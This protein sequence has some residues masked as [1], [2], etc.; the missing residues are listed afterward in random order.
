MPRQDV[1]VDDRP[2]S[3]G[4]T[5]ATDSLPAA[6]HGERTAGLPAELHLRLDQLVGWDFKQLA[7]VA[8]FQAQLLEG[9][10]RSFSRGLA[11]HHADA[12]AAL[13]GR[14]VEE[15][16][17][18]RHGAEARGFGS[19]AALAED[20]DVVRIAA[21]CADVAMH[22]LEAVADV[23]HALVA[24]GGILL[25]TQIAQEKKAHQ[26]QAMI[27]GDDHHIPGARQVAAI[28][29]IGTSRSRGEPATMAIKHDR[30]FAPVGGR[31]PDVEKEAVLS[32]GRLV[33]ALAAGLQGGRTQFESV[34]NTG[35]G[36]AR[37]RGFE[38]VGSSN[39]AGVRD[40]LERGQVTGLEPA[41]APIDGLDFDKLLARGICPCARKRKRGSGE[42]HGAV[43]EKAA[44]G[45]I[46]RVAIG[47][48]SHDFP[49][50]EG[51]E[52]GRRRS[53]VDDEG[54]SR[55]V[56]AEFGI[57]EDKLEVAPGDSGVLASQSFGPCT[58]AIFNCFNDGAVML[59]CDKGGALLAVSKAE[60]Q[61]LRSGEGNFAG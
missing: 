54:G 47:D 2:E 5:A 14:L 23:E 30:P 58:L 59:G 34:A 4:T 17:R 41:Q 8:L 53:E 19:A 45:E 33:A 25:A 49:F 26:A 9:H 28:L 61:R 36:G 18:G 55:Q 13:D 1:A 3:A 12:G 40:A 11:R 35:P 6:A 22:P 32:R 31:G 52:R 38:P 51:V 16:L 29:V 21:K 44:T 7:P 37:R 15:G 20:H 50:L 60:D 24:G 56:V 48:G 43:R 57:L 39:G 27:G 10:E 42:S 46:E